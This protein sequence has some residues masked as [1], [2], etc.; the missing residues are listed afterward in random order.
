MVTKRLSPRA[1]LFLCFFLFCA[2]LLIVRQLAPGYSLTE[3]TV[4]FFSIL[5][6]QYCLIET[7]KLEGAGKRPRR[8]K[9]IEHLTR[10][11][12]SGHDRTAADLPILARGKNAVFRASYARVPKATAARASSPQ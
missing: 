4:I 2:I 10:L 12:Q 5:F 3:L 7:G 9:R 11:S 8:A 1:G 6:I